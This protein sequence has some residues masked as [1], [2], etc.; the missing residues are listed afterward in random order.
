MSLAAVRVLDLSMGWAGPMVSFVLANLGAEVIKVEARR[1]FDWWRGPPARDRQNPELVHAHELSAVFNSVNRHKRG[2]TLD[3]SAAEGRAAL[4]DL[5]RIADVLVENF[6]PH[7]MEALG[8]SYATLGA[9]NPQLV[10]ISMP[11]FGATG[12]ERDYIGYGMTMEA[13][14]GMSALT[15]YE[16]GPPQ[17]LSNAYGDP[18]SGLNGAVAALVALRRRPETGRGAHVEVAQVEAFIPLV[19]GALLEQ[20]MTGRDPGRMGN[21]HRMGSTSAKCE[22]RSAKVRRTNFA[23]T[24]GSRSP[25]L[26]IRSGR[27]C[28]GR[29]GGRS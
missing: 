11:A 9:V 12:P 14:A 10:M 3:L 21:R 7:A 15:G 28:A 18:V 2:V 19:A 5:A 27:R 25:W 6:T 23:L 1:R 20:Q 8:L 16:D 4:L 17:M 24:P 29:S 26:P 22:V 13:M